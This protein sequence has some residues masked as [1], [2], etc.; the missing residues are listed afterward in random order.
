MKKYLI[1]GLV[2][3]IGTNILA[4]AGVAYNRSGEPVYQLQLTEREMS[5]PYMNPETREDSRHSLYLHWRMPAKDDVEYITHNV[6]YIVTDEDTLR[7]IGFTGDL[8]D[9]SYSRT[10]DREIHIALEYEG[11][12]YA[13]DMA[14]MKREIEQAEHQ[15][16][17]DPSDSNKHR[18]NTLLDDLKVLKNSTTRLYF[19]DAFVSY[20]ELHAKFQTRNNIVI[21]KALA[22]A[23]YNSR[24]D[25]YVLFINELLVPRV[26]LPNQYSSM[27]VDLYEQENK[28][29]K[30]RYTVQV[31]WGKR[32]EPWIVGAER[33]PVD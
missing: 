15:F 5:L 4:L 2:I 13:Q 20:D 6:T 18:V 24:D 10:T 27:F 9:P 16:N 3:I 12:L 25:E 1:L 32:L 8:K 14:K 29:D 7:R 11:E 26:M 23:N 22:R 17:E 33:L 19:A 21:V 31:N 30:P 28:D